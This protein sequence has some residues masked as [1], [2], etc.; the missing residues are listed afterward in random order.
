MEMDGGPR[1]A[2]SHVSRGPCSNCLF[3]F[4]CETACSCWFP[5]GMAQSFE[6]P[7]MLLRWWWAKGA[8][9]GTHRA[10]FVL[11]HSPGGW[12]GYVQLAQG[13]LQEHDGTRRMGKGIVLFAWVYLEVRDSPCECPKVRT[14]AAVARI[15]G[16]RPPGQRCSALSSGLYGPVGLCST[17]V[18]IR[19]VICGFSSSK[20]RR[21]SLWRMQV[22]CWRRDGT[23][24]T[25]PPTRT[26]TPPAAQSCSMRPRQRMGRASPQQQG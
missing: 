16:R 17:L 11:V 5:G 22:Q 4:D 23:T 14:A 6:A 3:C 8:L 10:E 13:K 2:L 15:G 24:N 18:S 20:K 12:D 7:R 9:A 19:R 25:P 21:E 26:R 1:Y